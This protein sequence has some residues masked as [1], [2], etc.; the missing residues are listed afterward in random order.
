MVVTEVDPLEEGGEMGEGRL[1]GLGDFIYRVV[2]VCCILTR[3]AQVD[4][5]GF[6][7]AGSLLLICDHI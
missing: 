2:V 4:W 5:Y 7:V 3:R 6:V 1:E